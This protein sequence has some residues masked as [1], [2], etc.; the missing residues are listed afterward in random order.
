MT[1]MTKEEINTIANKIYHT[2]WYYNY[3][4]D[5]SVYSR[6]ELQ[7]KQTINTMKEYEWNDINYSHLVESFFQNCLTRF[8]DGIIP[9]NFREAW[10]KRI[11]SLTGR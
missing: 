10:T 3:S 1:I 7:T 11:N 5:Y 9:D 4:D 8:K 2:D 6:G